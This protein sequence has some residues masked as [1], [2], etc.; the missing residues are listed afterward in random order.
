MEELLQFIVQH[1]VT[2]P[3]EVGISLQ[4]DDSGKKTYI[5][6]TSELDRAFVIGKKGSTINAIRKLVSIKDPKSFVIIKD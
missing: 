5:L 2:E 6:N 4:I 3:N 1:I